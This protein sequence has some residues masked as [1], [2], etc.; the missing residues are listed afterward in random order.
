MTM[1]QLLPDRTGQKLDQPVGKGEFDRRGDAVFVL[2]G[3]SYTCHLLPMV[4]CDLPKKFV[5]KSMA[6]RLYFRKTLKSLPSVAFISLIEV[7]L[8]RGRNV[9]ST[10]FCRLSSSYEREVANRF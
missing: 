1:L 7:N 3:K 2:C 4:I 10:S 6:I 9:G 8:E 5:T